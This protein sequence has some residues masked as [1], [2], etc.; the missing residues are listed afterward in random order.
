[1]TSRYFGPIS[2]RV[3]GL[4]VDHTK[5]GNPL[6]DSVAEHQPTYADAYYQYLQ[7]FCR[8]APLG[9]IITLAKFGDS[10]SFAVVY[11]LAAYFFSRKMGRLMLLM[12]PVASILGGIALGRTWAWS[13][14]Q[15]WVDTSKSENVVAV[16]NKPS[17]NKKPKKSKEFGKKVESSRFQVLEVP[18]KMF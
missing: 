17:K 10:P 15:F 4:F 12:A 8:I 11:G 6:V 13:L 3:R 18:L 9:F 5:T 14:E 2:S 7:H 1:M 16:T